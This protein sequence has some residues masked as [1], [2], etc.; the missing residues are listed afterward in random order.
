MYEEKEKPS[1]SGVSLTLDFW[2]PSLYSSQSP[3]FSLLLS[4][5]QSTSGRLFSYF[6][7]NPF[8]Q[9]LFSMK[10]PLWEN[11]IYISAY[12]QEFLYQ[13]KFDRSEHFTLGYEG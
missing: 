12:V 10:R 4:L 2:I 13:W 5:N 11:T 8:A 7:L 1:R 3:R 6:K 9:F